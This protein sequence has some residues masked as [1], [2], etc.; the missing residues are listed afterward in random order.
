MFNPFDLQKLT[1]FVRW[2]LSWLGFDFEFSQSWY[3]CVHK[4]ASVDVPQAYEQ[5]ENK[6]NIYL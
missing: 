1:K 2:N 3:M 4:D 5:Q 6:L